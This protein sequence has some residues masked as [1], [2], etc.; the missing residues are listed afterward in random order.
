M[1][2]ISEDA[3]RPPSRASFIKAANTTPTKRLAIE[4]PVISEHFALC[5]TGYIVHSRRGFRV[6]SVEEKVAA[7]QPLVMIAW[8]AEAWLSNSHRTC[9]FQLYYQGCPVIAIWSDVYEYQYG[10][11]HEAWRGLLTEK[12]RLVALC[13]LGHGHF[14]MN[15]TTVKLMLEAPVARIAQVRPEIKPAKAYRPRRTLRHRSPKGGET[16][17]R[18]LSTQ[19]GQ[20]GPSLDTQRPG[21]TLKASSPREST[22]NLKHSGSHAK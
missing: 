12:D 17:C 18:G 2:A 15:G 14:R 3:E 7:G 22:A 13:L 19:S 6:V 8:A 16:Q 9:S 20:L 21:R 4:V 5:A 11:H 1:D 10:Y